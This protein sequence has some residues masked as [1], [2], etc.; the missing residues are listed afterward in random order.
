MNRCHTDSPVLREFKKLTSF[1]FFR[2]RGPMVAAL[3][4]HQDIHPLSRKLWE[5]VTRQFT[6]YGQVHNE[7]DAYYDWMH[8]GESSTYFYFLGL[9]DPTVAKYRE[10]ASRFAGL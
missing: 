2:S 3:G 4:G 1:E 10:R 7:Y 9:A 5:A 8:H 6:G